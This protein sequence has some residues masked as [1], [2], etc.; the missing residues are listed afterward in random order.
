M[1]GTS[2][3]LAT[4]D[5]ARLERIYRDGMEVKK[6]GTL[7][8]ARVSTQFE[9]KKAQR[10]KSLPD[11]SGKNCGSTPG[12]LQ[13]RTR[14]FC[15]AAQSLGVLRDMPPEYVLRSSCPPVVAKRRV[16]WESR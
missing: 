10:I 9:K 6:M 5:I 8:V 7:R 15:V 3:F 2:I 14:T 16:S 11:S 13:A 4:E 12:A 1:F